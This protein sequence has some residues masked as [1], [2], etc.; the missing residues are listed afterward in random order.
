MG[1]ISSE[2]EISLLTGKAVAEALR[3]L[4]SSTGLEVI[5]L[6]WRREVSLPELIISNSI[7]IV[8]NA[9]HGT[10]GED[11]AVQGLLQCMRIPYTG[12][13]ILASALAMDK[14][15][16]KRLFDSYSLRNA[17][18]FVADPQTTY[19]IPQGWGKAVVK[20]SREGSSVGVCLCATDDELNQAI[21]ATVGMSGAILVERYIAGAELCVGIVGGRS[22]GA[23][24]I[25]VHNVFYDYA[26]KYQSKD[27]EYL[28]PP[29]LEKWIVDNAVAMSV[30]AYELVGCEGYARVDL[31]VNER[32]DGYLLEVNT[33]PGM[34]AKSLLPK[35]AEHAKISYPDL[36]LQILEQSIGSRLS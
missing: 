9:L 22:I 33:L 15:A 25:V 18:W 27:T 35:I 34:T 30:S 2:R 4:S 5:E 19:S 36:C 28:V 13:S 8:W 1:G 17:P 20:P 32:G 24:Q 6:D 29:N 21:Q 16:S 11:G 31:R 3:G 10:Y 14:V 23:L 7:D 12:S 26:A